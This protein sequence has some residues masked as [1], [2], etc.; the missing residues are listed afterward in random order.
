MAPFSAEALYQNLVRRVDHGAP[1]SV[2]LAQWPRAREEHIDDALI[3]DMAALQRVVEL[4]R[5]ARAN[6]GHKVRQPLPEVLVR[7]RTPEEQAGVARLEDQVAEELNVKVVRYLDVT[8]EFVDYTV[9]PDLP[10][11]GKRFGKRVPA[12]RAALAAADGRE[13][14]RLVRDGA[15][16]ELELDGE[17]VTLRPDE[18]LLDAKSPEGYA[19]VEDRGYLAAL[20]TTLTPEL[21]REGLMRDAVRLVQDARKQAGLEVSDRI[22]LG[23]AA[24]DP[25]AA[26]AISEHGDTVAGETLAVTLRHEPLDDAEFVLE[27]SLGA[28]ALR[29]SLRRA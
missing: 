29:V 23:L 21:R 3:R 12:L 7:L 20:N 10:K 1:L 14:A 22:V 24:D 26:A 25:E 18:V 9:K 28:G 16:I 19:A 27:T 13:I 15:P 17:R 6:S 2:H 4:G 5:A 11:V 8:D